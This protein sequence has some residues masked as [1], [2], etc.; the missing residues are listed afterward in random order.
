[1]IIPK[2][3][4]KFC[5]RKDPDRLACRHVV[6]WHAGHADRGDQPFVRVADLHQLVQ[7]RSC[8]VDADAA[9]LPSLR[10][11]VH[12]KRRG[13]LIDDRFQFVA[14]FDQIDDL[15]CEGVQ[16]WFWPP[17]WPRDSICRS[18]CR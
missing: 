13:E 17:E 12:S 11:E 7:E 1:M 18:F 3:V 6:C 15:F 8:R 2:G 14:F 16:V 4:T 10:A 9:V 5:G